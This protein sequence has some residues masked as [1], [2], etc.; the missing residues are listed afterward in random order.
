MCSNICSEITSEF[1]T[2]FGAVLVTNDTPLATQIEWNNATHNSKGTI[3]LLAVTNG[4]TAT[5]FSDFGSEHVITDANG[6]PP[7]SNPVDNIEVVEDNGSH[8]LVITVTRTKH[9]LGK[10]FFSLLPFSF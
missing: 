5:F 10:N 3:Y 4:V 7:I 2:S 1:L 9:D 6:E 8:H